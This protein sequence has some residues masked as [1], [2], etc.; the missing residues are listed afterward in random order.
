MSACTR[1]NSSSENHRRREADGQSRESCPRGR[2]TNH[3]GLESG[4]RIREVSGRGGEA[5]GQVGEAGGR[6]GESGGRIREV[7][8]RT[9][10]ANG[11]IA[12]LTIRTA[13]PIA[14]FP[15]AVIELA[16]PMPGFTS[17]PPASPRRC[18]ARRARRPVSRNGRQA[19]R[20][21]RH[22]WVPRWSA[23]S[24]GTVTARTV[25]PPHGRACRRGS[26]SPRRRIR[27]SKGG[28][29]RRGWRRFSPFWNPICA[30]PPRIWSMPRGSA[31]CWR[32]ACGPA[33]AFG[34][35]R[36]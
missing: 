34:A 7:G 33:A 6:I 18:A 26:L 11:G 10:E 15:A 28:R 13:N 16:A 35:S 9:G 5:E 23:S 22:R 14:C 31:V 29:G 19:R 2:E 4:S 27:D 12:K 17:S 32:S 36:S 20:Y 1:S 25:S 3:R 8:C 21:D 30:T 24:A